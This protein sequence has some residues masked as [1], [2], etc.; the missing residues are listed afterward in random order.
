MESQC[1]SISPQT[2]ITILQQSIK[3]HPLLE[4]TDGALAITFSLGANGILS[5]K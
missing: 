3:K 4:D 2:I 5:K 1:K